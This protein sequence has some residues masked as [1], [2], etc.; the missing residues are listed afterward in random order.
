MLVN[1]S[2]NDITYKEDK[3]DILFVESQSLDR[4][5]SKYQ[6]NFRRYWRII[7]D[8]SIVVATVIT[9]KLL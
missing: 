1:K 2:A 8:R 6:C 9:P 4:L 5:Y 3:L 7:S